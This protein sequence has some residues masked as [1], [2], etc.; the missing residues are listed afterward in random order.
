MPIILAIDDKKDNLIVLSALLKNL[1]PDCVVVTAMSGIE[2]INKANAELPDV[3]LLDVKM[4]DMDGFETCRRLKADE[5]T[6]H[7][8]VIMIT[9]I[10]TDPQSRVKGLEIGADAFVAKP[11]DEVELV[12]QVKVALRI[13]KAEDGLR[14]EMNL[15]E[16][17]VYERTADLREEIDFRKQAEDAL[18]SSLREK[19]VLLKELQHRVK[20]N[21]LTISGILALQLSRMKD[22][23]SKDA[24][25]TSVNRINAL[26]KI[27]TRL[28]QSGDFSLIGFKEYIEEL[29]WELSRSYEFPSENII[30]DIQDISL[31]I[32]TAIPAGLMVNELVSNAMKHA[33]PP[34]EQGPWDV[35]RRTWDEKRE[36]WDESSQG[37]K[38]EEQ[39]NII[40]VSL[41]KDEE[42]DKD[43]A[44]CLMLDARNPE[45]DARCLMLDTRNPHPRQ[46]RT[47]PVTLTVSDNGIGFPAHLDINNTESIGLSLLVQLVEQINGTMELVRDKGTQ[48]IIT[49]SID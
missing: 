23:E 7:I 39:R 37:A 28:Y 45:F 43:D 41:K 22:N 49:F 11:I 10:R 20:N 6:R 31:D 29:L 14:E 19:N 44:R 27:H 47:G 1:L 2:G 35:G 32:N 5:S 4:P 3:I 33:F 36:A 42:D 40:T 34:E 9:A 12:S 16:K 46:A 17:I 38:G 15:L 48:F 8:P 25:I 24:L 18:K 13:K 30:T 21:L 26:T